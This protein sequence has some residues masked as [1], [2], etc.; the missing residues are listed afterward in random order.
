MWK[1][2]SQMDSR[3]GSGDKKVRKFFAKSDLGLISLMIFIWVIY[4]WQKV[5][6]TVNQNI[7]KYLQ[8]FFTHYGNHVCKACA[9]SL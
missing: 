8:H 3:S 7:L 1:I 2:V 5:Y 9:K 6:F 4:I